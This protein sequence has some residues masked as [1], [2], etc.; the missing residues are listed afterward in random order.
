MNGN[1]NLGGSL[2]IGFRNTYSQFDLDVAGDFSLG[3]NATATF[4]A[5]YADVSDASGAGWAEGGG[6]VR[7][8]GAM[9]IADGAKLKPFCDAIWGAPV[10]FSASSVTIAEG[11][12]IY[13]YAAGWGK[14]Y[15]GGV[16]YSGSPNR[17]DW[18]TSS[19][20]C[21]GTYAGVGGASKSTLAS[22]V[23]YGNPF[24]PYMPGSP[25]MYNHTYYG[26]GVV[27]IHA[28]GSFRCDGMVSA[29]GYAPGTAS[30]PGCG[31]G[32]S[33]WITCG[34]FDSGANASITAKGGSRESGDRGAGGGGRICIAKGLTSAQIEQ[35]YM[36]GT[37][38]RFA[39]MTAIDLMDGSAARPANVG[40]TISAAGGTNPDASDG[41]NHNGTDGTAMMLIN[42]KSGLL[43]FVR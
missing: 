6:R 14:T 32:G 36:T 16:T 30:D 17:A 12:A 41:Y 9:T 28:S 27:R 4:Y 7:V 3:M 38:S 11:G 15:I 2:T 24:A 1:L 31:S 5:G 8:G 21:G 35:L 25:D 18:K 34:R 37:C 23:T 40:G 19:S 33:V 10:V 13:A 22:Q 39:K 42:S 29:D 20:H 26:G 43:I